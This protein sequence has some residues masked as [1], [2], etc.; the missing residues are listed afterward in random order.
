[1]R[2]GIRIGRAPRDI[3]PRANK[4]ALSARLQGGDR[5]WGEPLM[6]SGELSLSAIP[7][8]LIGKDCG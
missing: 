4:N 3:S 8:V 2:P 7:R 5:G 1:M 6:G